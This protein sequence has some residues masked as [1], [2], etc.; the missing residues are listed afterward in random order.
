MKQIQN[1]MQECL[2]QQTADVFT[3]Y[4]NLEITKHQSQNCCAERSG[5]S[6]PA[7][8]DFQGAH[9]PPVGLVEESSE[10]YSRHG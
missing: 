9:I 4:I 3:I 7:R 1:V 6:P 5:E 2:K 10:V 8:M